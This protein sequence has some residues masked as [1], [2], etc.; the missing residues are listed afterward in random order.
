MITVEMIKNLKWDDSTIEENLEIIKRYEEEMDLRVE[1]YW[2]N[3]HPSKDAPDDI[4]DWDQGVYNPNNLTSKQLEE[5]FGKD[6]KD[7]DIDDYIKETVMR[8]LR[9]KIS[10]GGVNG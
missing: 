6:H 3:H 4:K 7:L 9:I 10:N 5:I 8:I 2:D 1:S